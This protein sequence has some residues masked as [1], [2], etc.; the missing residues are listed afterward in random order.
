MTTGL[1]VLHRCLGGEE[2]LGTSVAS[3]LGLVVICSIHMLLAGI[4]GA[5][6]SIAGFALDSHPVV[7][8]IHVLVAIFFFI[9]CVG[10]VIAFEHREG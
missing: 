7:V 5:E 4:L 6:S 9:E 8:F 1:H 10:T 3:V 2:H